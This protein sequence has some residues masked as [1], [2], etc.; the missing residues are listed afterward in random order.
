MNV[1]DGFQLLVPANWKVAEGAAAPTTRNR[2]NR[3]GKLQG[4]RTTFDELLSSRSN[5]PA[6]AFRAEG[7]TESGLQAGVVI[8]VYET[9][10]QGSSAAIR[11]ALS[12]ATPTRELAELTVA[13]TT[14][15]QSTFSDAAASASRKFAEYWVPVPKDPQAIT[16]LRFWQDGQDAGEFAT[17][18][19]RMAGSFG[20]MYPSFWSGLNGSAARTLYRPPRPDEMPG[21]P[22][23]RLA[24][25]RLG[26]PFHTAVLSANR[27]DAYREAGARRIDNVAILVVFVVW[28]TA[29]L[30]LVGFGDA[31]FLA[32][33]TAF[34]AS[35]KFARRHRWRAAAGLTVILATLLGV[36]LWF[37]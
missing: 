16:L 13:M 28:I 14:A 18:H 33:G 5:V 1:P 26:A 24:G 11:R 30:K 35:I 34:M 15:V 4:V 3:E 32:G 9:G 36:S 6:A 29:M 8:G 37:D 21:E 7:M 22:A 17:L 25:V 20:F 23:W 10:M 19:D 27:A 12:E 2:N 31:V